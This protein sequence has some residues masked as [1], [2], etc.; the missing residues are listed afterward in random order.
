VKIFA[1][2][3]LLCIFDEHINITVHKS[4]FYECL[5]LDCVVFFFCRSL[6]II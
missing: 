6:I 5:S 3:I 1:T 2:A 4:F